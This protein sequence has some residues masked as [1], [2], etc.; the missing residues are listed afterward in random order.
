MTVRLEEMTWPEVAKVLERPNLIIW[1]IGSIEEHG[2]HLPLNVD[3]LSPTHIAEKTA[4]RVKEGYGIDVLVAPTL[5]YTEVSVHRMFPGTIGIRVETLINVV[6]DVVRCFIGQGFKNIIVFTAHIQN[7]SPIEIALRKVWNDFPDA[8]I[9]GT[10]PRGLGFEVTPGLIKNFPTGMCHG[11]EAE[12]AQTLAIRPNLVHMDRAVVGHR[13]SP[14]SDKYLG[15]TG[16]DT[17]KVFFYPH[18]TGEEEF[19]I[20]GDP[21]GATAEQGEKMLEAK[22]DDL[23]DIISQIMKPKD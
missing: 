20:W 3:S 6:E 8:Q 10:T 12:T 13:Q 1:P 19:G 5:D 9:Y 4:K 17:S 15:A 11:G 18:G 2:P 7:I 22:V 16:T 21:T 23:T 14:L